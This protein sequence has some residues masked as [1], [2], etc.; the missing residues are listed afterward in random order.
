MSFVVFPKNQYVSF[1]NPEYKYSIETMYLVAFTAIAGLAMIYFVF[2]FYSKKQAAEKQ[3][4][5]VVSGFFC[6][7][8]FKLFFC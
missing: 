4:A 5:A 7:Y 6:F 2:S 3:A 1:S 8:F